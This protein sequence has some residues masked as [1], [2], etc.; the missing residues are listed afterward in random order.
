MNGIE[1]LLSTNRGI[2]EGGNGFG[3]SPQASHTSV[4]IN[5]YQASTATYSQY[6]QGVSCEMGRSAQD[7]ASLTYNESI[8][9]IKAALSAD[10]KEEFLEELYFYAS[11]AVE[12]CKQEYIAALNQV[13]KAWRY[14]AMVKSNK[15]FLR[16]IE[17]LG[18]EIKSDPAPGVPWKEALRG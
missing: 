8:D 12:T 11:Q 9:L 14:T 17:D 16:K 6:T 3:S 15:D 1:G 2:I 5:Y 7:D 10:E 18:E 13:L 4:V